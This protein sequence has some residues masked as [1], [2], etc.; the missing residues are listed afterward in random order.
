MTTIPL[1]AT[2]TGI[3]GDG[4]GAVWVDEGLARKVL[5]IIPRADGTEDSVNFPRVPVCCPGPGEI[6]VSG[7]AVFVGNAEG[8]YELA[9]SRTAWRRIASAPAAGAAV[10]AGDGS[11]YFSTLGERAA[12]TNQKPPATTRRSGSR[13]Q[14]PD[15]QLRDPHSEAD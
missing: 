4:N 3:A 13:I 1:Q 10:V 8:I 12:T 5:E 11:V 6:A 9:A 14:T 7:S 2:P 15:S